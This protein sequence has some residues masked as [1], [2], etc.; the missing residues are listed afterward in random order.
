MS[1]LFKIVLTYILA[2]LAILCLACSLSSCSVL[3][4]K[5]SH[6]ENLDS[7]S[8]KVEKVDSVAKS[9]SFAVRKSQSFDSGSIV[10]EFDTTTSDRWTHSI[11]SLKV[12]IGDPTS[13]G[14][15]GISGNPADYFEIF[16]DGTIKT[17][18]KLSRVTISGTH[19]KN[20]ID[21]SHV[22]NEVSL[23]KNK[24][25]S[26]H[27]KL[28][29]SDKSKEVHRSFNPLS[30]WWLWLIVGIIYWQRKRIYHLMTGL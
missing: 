30:L 15:T 25:D 8:V 16:P 3:K 11:D 7:T 22:G 13:V 14:H 24:V 28:S 1:H 23:S 10:I 18:K 17:N 20:T 27:V 5:S 9:D 19:L 2:L 12:S 26:T 6:K 4:N 29:I 21:S